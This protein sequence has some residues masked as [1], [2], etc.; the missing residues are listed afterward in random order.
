MNTQLNYQALQ[1]SSAAI[2]NNHKDLHA[3]SSSD[4][5]SMAFFFFLEGCGLGRE[6]EGVEGL[7]TE[8]LVTFAFSQL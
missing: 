4:N 7:N 8:I 5:L 2:Q 3:I 6:R 1:L